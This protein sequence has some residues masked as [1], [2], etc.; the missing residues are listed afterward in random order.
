MVH[1]SGP[2]TRDRCT[3]PHIRRNCAAVNPRTAQ[4]LVGTNLSTNVVHNRLI[5]K[6]ENTGVKR[7]V[8]RFN[9]I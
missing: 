9:E 8:N 6:L 4:G 1:F 7:L 5:D 2:I 3:K